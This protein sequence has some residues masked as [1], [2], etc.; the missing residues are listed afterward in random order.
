MQSPART[1]PVF[2]TYGGYGRRSE[3]SRHNLVAWR[4]LVIFALNLG[5]KRRIV[6]G[7]SD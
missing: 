7:A 6:A 3:C 4:D 1:W 5:A 2:M